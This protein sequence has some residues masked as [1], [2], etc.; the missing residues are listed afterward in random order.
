MRER[1]RRIIECV[2][3]FS[4]GRDT[5][6][7]RRIT[8]EI[9][10][11]D[12]VKLLDVDPGAATNRTVVTFAGEP[13]P[14]MEAAFKAI[15]KASELIDMSRHRGEHPRFGATDVCPLIPISNITMEETVSYARKLGERVGTALKIPVYCY[16]YAA[17]SDGRRNLAAVRAGEYEGLKVKLAD[18]SW[19]P[20]FGPALFN[21]KSGAT[22]IG[23][24]NALIAFNVNLNT[25]D[26]KLAH[27]VAS[28]VRE[29][30]RVVRDRDGKEE[31]IPGNL[32][33]VKGMG[34]YIDEYKICQVSMNLTDTGNTPLHVVFDEV[35]EKARVKGLRATGS[36]IVGLIPL[37]DMLA[38][39][40]YYLGKQDQSI[41]VPEERLLRTAVVTLGLNELKPFV[42]ME[43]IIEYA[44]GG[45][46]GE[47]LKTKERRK[48]AELTV[49]GLIAETSSDSPAPGGGSVSAIVG[50]FGAALGTMVANLSARKKGWEDRSA[51]F[52]GQAGTGR[53][54]TEE[55]TRLM[56]EDTLAFNAIM[57]AYGL[58]KATDAEK[59]TR[60]E[61]I[62]E[63]TKKAIS[64]P[65]R[66]MEIALDSM[67]LL[68][69]MAEAGNSNSITDAG[70]GALCAGAAVAGA[71]MNVRVN[72]KYLGDRDFAGRVLSEGE[73]IEREA[74][75]KEKEIIA[76]VDKKIS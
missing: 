29:K 55:L 64:V 50:A 26:A 52:S 35:C 73:R 61:R 24:R 10:N 21:A 76:M 3:N 49:T 60:A 70:V 56:D 39:G 62:E 46:P 6:T 9:K 44:L 16:E 47:A 74:L 65:L 15:R 66:V 68:K 11:V 53:K 28:E 40:R 5:E 38:A 71:F 25:T 7:I 48:L 57:E 18:P 42:P 2:P 69:A 43:K 51:E 23:A 31:R 30:G 67:D 19:E 59:K 33:N 63:A 41:D 34:W 37:R 20:D 14:V 45:A 27:A 4:E 58:P 12:G 54:E 1:M 75:E 36:E 32:K 72:A 22:A 8:D 13:E 17:F